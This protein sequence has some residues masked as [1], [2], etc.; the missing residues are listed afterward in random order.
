MPLQLWCAY[1]ED[2]INES[3]AQACMALLTEGERARCERYKFERHRRESLATRAL[4]RSALSCHRPIP[5]QEWEFTSNVHG[6]PALE[7][8]CGLRFNLSNSV[9]LVA[10]LISEAAEVGLDLEPFSRAETMLRVAGEVFSRVERA[11]LEALPEGEKLDRALSLW[12]LKEAYVKARGVGFALPLG[13]FSF[14]FGGSE[15]VS[16][17]LDPGIDDQAERWRYFLFDHAGHRIAAVV[18]RSL[19]ADLE[20]LE[21]RS[22]LA[23][24]VRLREPAVEWFPR[25]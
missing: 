7:P 9:E 13:K 19:P 16:L 22:V 20:V 21:A 1:P 14:V 17:Q 15:G 25:M 18:E 11:Q 3:A 6:K 10:C 4:V 24:P 23:P 2:L 12:T 8:D 5:P